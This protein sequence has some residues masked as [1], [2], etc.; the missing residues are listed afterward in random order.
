MSAGGA[1]AGVAIAA[2]ARWRRHSVTL[3]I[4]RTAREIEIAFVAGGTASQ[5]GADDVRLEVLR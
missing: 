3:R 1:E 4:P 2:S 5:L